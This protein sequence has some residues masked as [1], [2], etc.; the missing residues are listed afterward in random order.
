[1]VGKSKLKSKRNIIIE[2]N[3]FMTQVSFGVCFIYRKNYIC[4]YDYIFIKSINIVIFLI[5]YLV[6]KRLG[7]ILDQSFEIPYTD[8]GDLYQHLL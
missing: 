5:L 7:A 6:M 1:M 2:L 4:L 3:V 8:P